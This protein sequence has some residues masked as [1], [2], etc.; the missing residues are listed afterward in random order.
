MWSAGSLRGA[1]P[2]LALQA[3]AVLELRRRHAARTPPPFLDFVQEYGMVPTRPVR[4]IAALAD[5]IIAGEEVRAVLSMPPRHGKTDTLLRLLAYLLRLRPD[6]MNAYATY[7]QRLADSK[8]RRAQRFAEAAGVRL[9]TRKAADWRTP[10]DGGLLATGVGGPLIGEGITGVGLIDDPIKNRL[11][12]ESALM[13]ERLWDW[14]TDVFL[15]RLEP[16]ASA[17]LVMHRWHPDDL[18]G[19][20][21][22]E[23]WEG[24]VLPA[25]DPA[26]G[27]ALWPERYPVERLERIKRAV[28]NYSWSSLYMGTPVPRGARVFHEPRTYRDLPAGPHREAHGFDAAY[29]EST[30]A[31]YSVLLTGRVI[32]DTLYLTGMLRQQ[33][34]ADQFLA[35]VANRGVKRLAWR[36]AGTEKGLESFFRSRGIRVDVM[37]AVGD[38]YVSAQHVAADWNAGKVAVPEEGSPYYGAWV[39]VLLDEV[40][41]FTGVNDE[42]DD[43]VDALTALHHHLIVTPAPPTDR[44]R[45]ALRA[46]A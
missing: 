16:G 14:F 35:T 34:E 15:T 7:A 31:D 23:G 45:S 43:I 21:I 22:E 44:A 41:G 17:I 46:I 4:A 8:S 25:I 2:N 6:R 13:R 28:G 36:R 3:Q 42:H 37:P 5:R 33:V 29:T 32:G 38:K 18:A 39:Q 9:A 11:E 27:E 40:L 10:S 30:R 24:V 19:R 1:L 12:A 20:L 26:T